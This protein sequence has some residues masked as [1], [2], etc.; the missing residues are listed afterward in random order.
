MSNFPSHIFKSYD[1]RGLWKTEL[2][3][4]L[5]YALGIAYIDFLRKQGEDFTHKKMVVGRDMRESSPSF[6]NA[7]ISGIHA[8]GVSVVNIGMCTT[9]LFNFACAHLEEHAGGIMVTASHNPAEYNGFKL[10]LGNGL[11]VGKV[12]GMEEIRDFILQNNFDTLSSNKS[13]GLEDLDPFTLYQ[14]RIFDLVSPQSI[15]SLKIVIDN[16]NG[17]GGVTFP[18]FLKALPQVDVEYL[19]IEPDG[20]FPNH[21]ANPLKTETLKDLQ[22]KVLEVNADFGFALDG[23][24]DRIGL[25]NE[26]GEVVDASFT[27]TLIGQEVLKTNLGATMLYDLR[28]S[29]IVKEVWEDSGAK[30]QMTQ[31]G[32]TFIKKIMSETN[33]V[34]GSELSLHLYY[35]DMYKVECTEL[36][37]MYLL[38][39]VSESGK[40][41][42]ELTE[43]LKKY[44]HSGEINFEVEDKDGMMQKI[45]EKYVGEAIRSEDLDGLWLEFDWGWFSVRESNTEP[46]LRLNVEAW[47]ENVMK[48]KFD[49]LK[50][51]IERG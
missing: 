32:H 43:S 45:R 37:L 7:V 12:N 14:E 15:K 20:T 13:G 33:A 40:S 42:G 17:M 8:Q 34:F 9:P 10:S 51:I 46:V 35:N 2:S 49:E 48:E 36:S 23:D 6:A 41:I 31:V 24:A 4:D 27:I 19:Y 18:R 26:K 39:L 16:A 1:I 25:V 44:Y 5:A 50:G 3:E 38:R 22:A 47:E 21:E 29:R 11:A 30:T 28:S